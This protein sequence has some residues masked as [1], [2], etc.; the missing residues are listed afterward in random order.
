MYQSPFK[1]PGS[2]AR[3]LP[4]IA[5][6]IRRLA[7][8]GGALVVPFVGAGWE[9]MSVL[10][11]REV[12]ARTHLILAD[13]SPYI[14]RFWMALV[15]RPDDV[16]TVFD[17]L[18]SEWATVAPAKRRAA[19]V[20]MREA[21][22]D[23]LGDDCHVTAAYL[24]IVQR[25]AFNGLFRTNRSGRLNVPPGSACAEDA[26]PVKWLDTR[27]SLKGAVERLKRAASVKVLHGDWSDTLDFALDHYDD[28]YILCDPPYV[29]T[30]AAYTRAGFNMADQKALIERLSRLPSAWWRASITNSVDAD[31]LFDRAAWDVMCYAVR[32][33][34]SCT[35]EARGAAGEIIAVKK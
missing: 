20:H 5:P 9:P 18:A 30:H 35:S 13:S 17:Q 34:I 27:V 6:H 23:S 33:S 28:G 19:Y 25:L 32:R 21:M 29:K 3:A 11:D 22:S 16:D 14:A 10:E 1:Y 24:M 31:G 4:A 2:K 15:E 12:A 26:P 7:W 8:A